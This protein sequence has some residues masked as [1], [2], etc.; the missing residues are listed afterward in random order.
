MLAAAQLEELSQYVI[1]PP[2]Q[3][4]VSLVSL[5]YIHGLTREQLGRFS[6]TRTEMCSHS[7]VLNSQFLPLQFRVREN[8]LSLGSCLF[9]AEYFRILILY[10]IC[11]CIDLRALE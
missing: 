7:N 3:C 2:T 1:P 10:T 8:N 5:A 4:L 9:P 6:V 11:Y